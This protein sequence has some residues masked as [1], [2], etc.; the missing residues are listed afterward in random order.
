[1]KKLAGQIQRLKQDGGEAS[2]TPKV[3]SLLKHDKYTV[4]MFRQEFTVNGLP[5][6]AGSRKLFLKKM[7]N[8]WHIEGDVTEREGERQFIAALEKVNNDYANNDDIR[9]S[10]IC[11]WRAGKRET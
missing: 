8:S 4:A 2:F 11:G 3:L 1:M 6:E 7:H 9:V 5:Y 10:S